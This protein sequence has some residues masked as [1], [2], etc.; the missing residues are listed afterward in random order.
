MLDDVLPKRV[1]ASTLEGWALHRALDHG[2]V[3]TRTRS[4]RRLGR[5]GLERLEVLDLSV[6]LDA[7]LIVGEGRCDDF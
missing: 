2:E 7:E 3:M 5:T 6:I 1:T 4:G